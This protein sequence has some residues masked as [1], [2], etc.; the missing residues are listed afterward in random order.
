MPGIANKLQSVMQR[1]DAAASR[2][3][4]SPNEVTLVA[5]TKTRS[6]EEIKEAL[7]CG[8][9]DIG[10][11]YVQEAEAKYAEI[12][13]NAVRWHMIGHLQRNK[14]KHAVEIFSLIHSVDSEALAREIG[15]RA[16]AIGKL[17]DVLVEVKISDEAT[18]FGV[19]PAEALFLVEKISEISGIRV[20]GLMGMAP[21]VA[22]PE[23][24]RP[25]FAKLKAIW[26]KLPK[27]QRLY[28]SMG[29]TQDF[30]VAI[31]EGSNMVRIGTAIFG[32]RA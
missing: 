1:I 22:D 23:E 31:E 7:A 25:Y 3:G 30:E 11:N 15:R 29:M 19:E 21:I 16:E 2:S 8:V 26:D 27:E 13:E 14:V 4:R 17:A 12:G 32:P 5:V 10:E 24:T 20:C 28:L 6:V 9:T 18:K